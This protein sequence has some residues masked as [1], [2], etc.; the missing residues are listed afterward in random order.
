V[1]LAG[2]VSCAKPVD[3]SWH[4]E[5]GYRWRALDVP[6]RGREGFT[7]LDS[8]ATGLTHANVVNDEDA[9]A[10]R[11][12]IIGAGVAIADVD[13]DGLSDVFLASVERP[14]ALYHNV[15]RMK[16]V[17]VTASSGI[18]TK[19]LA[20]TSAVL[21]DVDGDGD[22]D[23][24]VGTLGG[25][26]KLFL[27]DGKG[28]FTD[29]TATSG[30]TGGL[31][32]TTMT[33]ADV[34]GD[35]DLDLYVVTYKTRN[36]LDAYPPQA[37]QFDQVV[38]KVGDSYEV[39]DEWK[40]EYRVEDRP[41]LGGIARFQR[42]ERDLFFLNDGKGHFTEQPT[43]GPRWRDEEGNPLAEA[44]DYF[45]LSARFYDVNGDGA[46]DLY[47]CN[48]FED[49]DQFWLN[50]GK[51]NFRL[52]PSNAVR[53]TSNTCMS[54]D[55]GDVNRDGAVDFFTADMLS[56]TLA[57][58]QRQVPTNSPM[59]KTIGTAPARGQWMRN[60]LQVSRGNGTWSQLADFAGVSASD[61]TWGT[62]FVDVD[63]DGYEDLLTVAGDRW[64]VRDADTYERLRNRFPRVPWNRELGEFPRLAVP[65][66]AFHNR[67]D[68]TFDDRT[69]AWRF[70]TDSAISNVLALA[71]LDG[72]GDLDAVVG[73]LDA[74]PMVYRNEASAAR[75][76]VRLAGRSP[77]TEGI[78]AV[79][80]VRAAS[81]PVQSREVTSGGAYLSSND[82]GL[83]FATGRDTV[84]TL[85]VRWRDGLVSTI[86]NAK[87]NRLYEVSESGAVPQNEGAPPGV[88]AL[89]T[90]ATPLLSGHAHA[91][92]LFD[93][94][95]RQPLLPNR[96]SQLGPGVSWIDVD[97]DGREDL[98][99]GAGRGGALTVLR[100]TPRGFVPSQAPAAS[101]DIGGIVP[102]WSAGGKL[103][104]LASQSSYEAPTKADAMA[105]PSVLGYAVGPAARVAAAAPVAG[106]DSA[107]AGALALG[108]VNGDGIPDLFVAARVKPR[109]WPLPAASRLLLGTA[110]GTFA[111][112]SAN[113]HVLA[114][115]G[116]V[117]GATFAD[118]NGDGRDDLIVATEWGPVRVLLNRN[119]HLEDATE[120]LG[121]SKLTSRWN[122]VTVGDFDGD[123][124]LDIVATNWGLNVPWSA[125]ADR[126]LTMIVGDFGT[127]IGTLFAQ[128]D[129]VSGRELPL[130]SFS[131][132]G[133]AIPS[134]RERIA[135]YTD[136]SHSDAATILGPLASKV[137][138]FSAT[139]LQH[140]LFLNRGDHFEAKPLPL[141]AQ[142]ATSMG[143]VVADF[144]GDGHED[145]FLAQNFFPTEV[146]T[147]RLDAGAGLLLRGDGAGGFTALSVRASG[148]DV[149]GDQRGAAAAD[150]DGDGRVDLAV[151]QNGAATRLF[152]NNAGAPGL[153]VHL[154]GGANNRLGI[155]AQLRVVAND[156]RSP[157]REVRAGTG[158]WSMDGAVTVLARPA[159]A[160]S[161]EVRWPGGAMQTVP[162]SADQLDITIRR[163]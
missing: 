129:S 96:L 12:L 26:I 44:P 67:G 104:L 101:G 157:V 83:T 1:A 14:S 60:M 58:R 65:G 133:V 147:M 122:G 46:P 155:G 54:L 151:A 160:Q 102:V 17:D 45:G 150:F 114:T 69:T 59:P 32:A 142:R 132:L 92:S 25:P 141:E 156:K 40:K 105:L 117:S 93:D 73:R 51:G 118:V 5:Q 77:N 87:P 146:G 154:D 71:D 152:R 10:N 109:A 50:D 68:L 143:V 80:M 91:E 18:D 125:S 134:V 53:E 139:T 64:D 33:L 126:P 38:R 108:D 98:V 148:I 116:L 149:L 31:A 2:L 100:N 81:L 16:F 79:I 123:G 23:L 111:P 127:S 57:A 138:R 62:A 4:Q 95:T 37:R 88:N 162:I 124:Q 130:E 119:G 106:A 34:D 36:A 63:L 135:T 112:D 90:D 55:F 131:R 85:E 72:D 97:G 24:L 94:F 29:A 19:R 41:D 43:F 89:F 27:N 145:L 159:H 22:N 9:L 42:A 30:L 84:F 11:N 86:S 103:T 35:G 128:K 66:V 82:P 121:L 75:V 137:V 158:Y 153:R 78:G 120:S 3:T 107:T 70:E 61:W 140:T 49:P 7:P 15:G 115:L 48:D 28:H 20:A 113:A 74:P 110:A 76:A 144:D 52:A 13:G 21:A 56:P 163:P 161:I 47:V 39:R 136:Y 8:Q 99:I 6:R